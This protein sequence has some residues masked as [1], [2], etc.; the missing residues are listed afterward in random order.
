[1]SQIENGIW[2]TENITVPATGSIIAL[3]LNRNRR[4]LSVINQGVSPVGIILVNSDT[5][6]VSVD[7]QANSEFSPEI[8]PVNEIKFI[9]YTVADIILTIQ[10]I[11]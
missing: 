8:S 10:T 6:E 9:N 5:S 1:M 4:M 2:K 11:G 3:P 7:I